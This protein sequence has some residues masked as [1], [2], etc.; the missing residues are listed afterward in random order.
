[1]STFSKHFLIRNTFILFPKIDQ[2]DSILL[3]MYSILLN[4]SNSHH[5]ISYHITTRH[6]CSWNELESCRVG[7]FVTVFGPFPPVALHVAKEG[8][9]RG[10]GVPALPCLFWW[11]TFALRP[12]CLGNWRGWAMACHMATILQTWVG[13]RQTAWRKS[14]YF[15]FNCA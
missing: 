9:V 5:F 7:L 2:H 14:R 12:W 8:P 1:M 6:W 3:N 13:W 10:L 4:K 15:L 11:S